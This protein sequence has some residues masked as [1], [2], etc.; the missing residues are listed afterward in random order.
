MGASPVTVIVSLRVAALSVRS[1]VAVWSMTSTRLVRLSILKPC[2]SAV[3]VYVP[4]G[5]AGTR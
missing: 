3:T 2:N 5:N 1:S 4:G